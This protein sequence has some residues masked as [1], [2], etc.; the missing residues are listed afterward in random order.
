MYMSV[1]LMSNP[2]VLG[3]VF[4]KTSCNICNSSSDCYS[5]S[6]EKTFKESSVKM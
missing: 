3:A 5:L 1:K 2:S 4:A 6:K